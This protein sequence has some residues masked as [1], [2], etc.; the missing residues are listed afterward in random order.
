MPEKVKIIIN[1]LQEKGFEAYLVGGCVRDSILGTI[2][3]DWDVCTSARPEQILECF[4]DFQVVETGLKHGTVTVIID[5]EPFE[6]T[7][8]RIDGTYTDNRHPDSVIFTSNLLE[9]LSRRDFTINAMAYNEE[10]GLQDPFGGMVDIS[11][12]H[13]RCVGDADERFRE[14][15]LRILRAVRFA[16]QLGFKISE[17]TRVSMVNKRS[18]LANMSAERISSELNKILCGQGV[19]DSLI[20]YSSIIAAAI[21]EIQPMIGFGQMNPHHIYDVW[22][23][24]VKAVSLVRDNIVLRLTMFFHDIGKP[25]CITIDNEGI[26]HFYGHEEHS[27]EIAYAVM[28]RLRY[29][30]RTVESVTTLIKNHGTVFALSR[31]AAKRMLNKLGEEKVKLLTEIR[32]ADVSAQSPAK[33]DERIKKVITFRQIIDEILEENQCFSLKDLAINGQDLIAI[34]MKEGKDIGEV[35]GRL[36]ESVIDEDIDNQREELLSRAKEIKPFLKQ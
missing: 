17:P 1:L 26:G 32:I 9:D 29:D 36:M 8:Y 22:E 6:V 35:L 14:D 13:I 18:S 31:R 28:K 7:T 15:A 12:R 33:L 19:Y 23:H 27:R 2:P 25:H 30:N 11:N 20:E 4:H 24:S 16:S 21:P 34:G 5:K 3:K 10:K